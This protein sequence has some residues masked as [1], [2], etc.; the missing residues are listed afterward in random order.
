MKWG[1]TL[2][3]EYRKAVAA[4]AEMML[5]HLNTVGGE[6]DNLSYGENTFLISVEKE[7][8]FID[9]FCKNESDVMYVALCDGKI[10]GNAIVEHNR[11]SRYSHR[12][13]ISLTVLREYWGRGVGSHLMEMMINFAIE[14]GI[15]L[16][17]LEAR[18]DNERA[19]S[20]YKKFGF[21]KS[22]EIPKFFKINGEYFGCVTMTLEL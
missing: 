20:L 2:D 9:K 13:E 14:N 22:G 4:D 15:E 12:A 1:G 16:L 7:A 21:V 8:K 10:V 5:E 11:I 6:T 19:I 18:A 3:I 17:Y